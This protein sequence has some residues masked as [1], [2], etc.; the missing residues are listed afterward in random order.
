MSRRT[1][2]EP[3]KESNNDRL[4]LVLAAGL[5]HASINASTSKRDEKMS[6][7]NT[8]K[9]KGVT[10]PPRNKSSDLTN[11]DVIEQAVKQLQADTATV[12]M[13][14]AFMSDC[15]SFMDSFLPCDG[16]MESS[17]TIMSLGAVRYCQHKGLVDPEFADKFYECADTYLS[18]LFIAFNLPSE[19]PRATMDMSALFDDPQRGQRQ[20]TVYANQP[21]SALLSEYWK[22]L[23]E[24]NDNVGRG[25]WA[26]V[27]EVLTI[28]LPIIG[29]LIFLLSQY[30]SHGSMFSS[31]VLNQLNTHFQ[32]AQNLVGGVA[33]YIPWW[34]GFL[35]RMGYISYASER[36]LLSKSGSSTWTDMAVGLKDIFYNWEFRR[37]AGEIA[38]G[39]VPA[40]ETYGA[41]LLRARWMQDMN[42]YPAG[43]VL[44]N[45]ALLFNRGI[46]QAT[47]YQFESIKKYIDVNSI[48][49]AEKWERELARAADL[50]A[51]LDANEKNARKESAE[52]AVEAWKEAREDLKE[53]I[54]D[55]K[56]VDPSTLALRL[57]FMPELGIVEL[58]R[59]R[60][61]VAYHKYWRR[62]I[63]EHMA[64]MDAAIT[65]M[66]NIQS[67]YTYDQLIAA[68][69]D[70]DQ[71]RPPDM[72]NDNDG[73]G[74]GGAAPPAPVP[75]R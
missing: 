33:A 72:N 41:W 50:Q 25:R 8:L 61:F 9:L 73:G 43:R 55:S 20:R 14:L 47:L 44:F 39:E 67:N 59:A 1:F 53:T 51:G 42:M 57:P 30:S 11:Q 6:G 16:S 34:A 13:E 66:T 63:T 19:T 10:K 62:N 46:T 12:E 27:K 22:G 56:K 45:L 2:S 21:F 26:G 23:R 36:Y 5:E 71:A 58:V 75:R 69:M 38:L 17:V 74:G 35:P 70:P 68:G 64:A 49:E 18:Y 31:D 32:E 40:V 65:T 3:H 15:F 4:S 48:K 52:E 24:F 7:N 37:G 28:L 60:N 54:K 29:N